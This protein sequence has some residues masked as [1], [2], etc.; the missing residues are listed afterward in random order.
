MM[1]LIKTGPGTRVEDLGRSSG[2]ALGLPQGGAFD[3]PALQRANL[4][5]G[6]PPGAA[7]LEIASGPLRVRLQRD[8]W[9]AVCGADFAI[10]LDG[11]PQRMGWRF[12]ARAG[13]LLAIDGP[14]Q[15]QRALL[16]VQ[17]GLLGPSRAVQMG[18]HLQLGEPRCVISRAIGLQEP[19]W[20]AE[21]RALPA[22][23]YAA[24]TPALRER[25][26]REEF[27][28]TS[29]SD[30]MGLRLQ[31]EPLLAGFGS[32][33]S[34]AVQPGLLQLPPDGQ[35]ILLGVDAQA[36]GGYPRLLCVIAADLWKLAQARPGSS[37]RFV[38]CTPAR[39][40][41]AWAAQCRELGRLRLV[42]G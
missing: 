1:E 18:A 14:R 16:A 21:L 12:A 37:L 36:T 9:L 26:W 10:S 5:V 35:P 38:R 23:E 25:L 19:V 30:R 31:G 4:L 40:R 17:G 11:Q 33:L 41:E 15:G 34:H 32:L 27:R 2:R 20:T 24:L 3:T 8:A 22:P 42:L 13:Q 28:V 29:H 7:G 6:N 39:A